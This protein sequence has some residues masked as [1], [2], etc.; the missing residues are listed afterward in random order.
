MKLSFAG[1]AILSLFAA[2]VTSYNIQQPQSAVDRRGVLAGG[3]A[4]ALAFLTSNN[5]AQALEACPKGSNNCISTTWT[6]PSGT[7]ATKAASTLKAVIE[8]YPQEGQNKVDMGGWTIVDDSFA[9]GKVAKI[10]Y[11]SGIGN[12]AKFFNGGKPFVDD[13]K[14]ELGSDGVVSVRSSSRIGDSD[15]GVNQKRLSYF[16]S[17]LR[18]EGWD[19]PDPTY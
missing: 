11:K 8:S 13:L 12:F 7:D 15:L 19:A 3:A 17:K 14:L 4:A 2:T 1:T 16:V 18:A 6:P 9:P 10:E 5:P